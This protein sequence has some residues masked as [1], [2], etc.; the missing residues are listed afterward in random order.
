MRSVL[1]IGRQRLMGKNEK[2]EVSP[3]INSA[4][5]K[6][7]YAWGSGWVLGQELVLSLS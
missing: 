1:K 5:L 6:A 4:F 7:H 3:L 2:W